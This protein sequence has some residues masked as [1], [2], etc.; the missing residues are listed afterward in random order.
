MG[1]KEAECWGGLEAG[2]F[3]CEAIYAEAG[4]VL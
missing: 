4:N 1:E 2:A 3:L